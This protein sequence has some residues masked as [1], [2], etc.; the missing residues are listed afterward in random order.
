VTNWE[1]IPALEAARSRALH[2]ELRDAYAVDDADYL[3]WLDGKPFDPAQMSWWY[4]LIRRTVNRGVVVRRARIVSEPVT[5]YV[6]FEHE[7]TQYN[8]ASGEEVRW[9]PR[10]QAS[11]LLLPGNDFW[12]FDRELVIFNHF[13]G[14]GRSSETPEELR[15][16]IELIDQV[17]GS[18]EAVWQRAIPHADFSI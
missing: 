16:E 14:D 2:L 18:F 11:D 4:E 8:L 17:A 3:Q 12:L 10:S 6:K 9:L 7:I 1:A 15:R 13:T 5:E